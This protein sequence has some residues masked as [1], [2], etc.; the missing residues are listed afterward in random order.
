MVVEVHAGLLHVPDEVG[1]RHYA[2]HFAGLQVQLPLASG[3]ELLCI[4]RE[5]T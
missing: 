5:R 1:G 2:H 3:E 4:C